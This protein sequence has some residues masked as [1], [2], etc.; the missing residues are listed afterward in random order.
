M[1]RR[2]LLATTGAVASLGL[3]AGIVAG[4]PG[5]APA[6]AAELDP[7]LAVVT[8]Y[9][10]GLATFDIDPA[11]RTEEEDD[12]LRDATWGPHYHALCVGPPA[13][14]TLAGALAGIRLVLHEEETCGA[15]QGLHY[16]HAARC[17]RLLRREGL[18]MAVTIA[19]LVE[20]HRA[21]AAAYAAAPING[22]EE[23]GA[24]L[25]SADTEAGDILAS[26]P[27]PIASRAD[28][29]AALQ[30]IAEDEDFVQKPHARLLRLALAYLDERA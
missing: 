18:N 11:E 23:E 24:F 14:T 1:N 30:H 10:A 12:A 29:V 22:Q 27:P 4:V 9:K 16:Q 25:A 20:R 6:P 21:F 7:L 2:Q 13:A 3:C 17:A 5:C 26:D 28:L 19:E 15:S 8:A